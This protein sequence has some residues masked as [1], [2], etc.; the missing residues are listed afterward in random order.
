MIAFRYRTAGA[1]VV[2]ITAVASFT[3]TA[4]AS[5]PHPSQLH[6]VRTLSSSYVGPLQ[7]AVDG[8]RV[9]VADSLTATLTR[10]GVPNPIRTNPQVHGDLAGVAVDGRTGAIAYT[11]SS[12]DHSITALTIMRA[13]KPDVVADLARFEKTRNPDKVR[14]YGIDYPTK[15]QSDALKV[16]GV[17]VSYTGEVDSHPYA[18]TSIGNGA[19]AVADAGGNDIVKV[20]RYGHVS[21]ISVLPR[22]NVVAS[23]AFVAAS[24]LPACLVGAV[25]NFEAVPTDVEKGPH[26]G[27]YVTA[28]PGGPEG[29]NGGN[30]GSV[31]K[32]SKSGTAHRIA[33]GFKGATN[34]AIDRHGRIY[35]AEISSGTISQI[36]GHHKHKVVLHLPGV[37]AVEHANGHLY[38]STSPAVTGGQG[39]GTVVQL[40][41]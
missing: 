18:V 9:Y 29:P 28:L 36:Y 26:G 13:G 23:A 5:P 25:Y 16:A 10:I 31:Y 37:V 21:L 35:V 34:L 8:S 20:N 40:G 33:T 27:L 22:Q 6:V 2:G 32:I 24:G 30:P 15:C 4:S 3:G 7:F 19:W 17:P 38:A 11:T 41:R 1:A 14:H 12:S 39:P